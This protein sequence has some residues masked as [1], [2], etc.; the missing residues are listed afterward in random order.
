M[1]RSLLLG[2]F[3]GQRRLAVGMPHYDEFV[4]WL[5]EHTPEGEDPIRYY[6]ERLVVMF[7]SRRQRFPEECAAETLERAEDG[8][9][10]IGKENQLPT[11][12]KYSHPWKLLKGIAANV[13][14]DEFRRMKRESPLS[15]ALG[16]EISP[17][18]QESEWELVNKYIKQ[19]GPADADSC[20]RYYEE[21]RQRKRDSVE[22]VQQH[23]RIKAI[24]K[25]LDQHSLLE[26]AKMSN[27][28]RP[29]GDNG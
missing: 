8:Y 9:D 12:Q 4:R 18:V 5:K 23:R 22:A 16:L 25:W 3:C 24:R 6:Y 15:E 7:S 28:R 11:R 1:E 14:A 26:N 19:F 2:G 13:N 17:P 21:F 10:P 20:L 27:L 29:H